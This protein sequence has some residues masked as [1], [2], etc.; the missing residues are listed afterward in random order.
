MPFQRWVNQRQQNYLTDS[1]GNVISKVLDRHIDALRKITHKG[2]PV[3][4]YG[5]GGHSERVARI[6]KHL[7]LSEIN[8]YICSDEP[9]NRSFHSAPVFNIKK[10][11]IQSPGLIIISS[12]SYEELMVNNSQNKFPETSIITFW[13]QELTQ[14]K[15]GC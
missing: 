7:G 8:A 11:P 13:N 5:T 9:E 6:W 15:T 1:L 14:I 4:V 12:M 10:C 3:L 2:L